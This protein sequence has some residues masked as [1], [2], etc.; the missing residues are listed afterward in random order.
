MTVKSTKQKT[1]V[2][3]SKSKVD[4]KSQIED[5]EKSQA[6][7]MIA[8]IQKES[9]AFT[10]SWNGFTTEMKSTLTVVKKYHETLEDYKEQMNKRRETLLSKLKEIVPTI[11]IRL[12]QAATKNKLAYVI[13]VNL[14]GLEGMSISSVRRLLDRYEEKFGPLFPKALEDK[15]GEDTDTEAGTQNH[16]DITYDIFGGKPDD[17]VNL[18]EGVLK[19]IEDKTFDRLVIKLNASRSKIKGFRLVVQ[20]KD[21]SET[22]TK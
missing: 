6:K 10:H 11:K 3:E 5:A 22:T 18:F 19:A 21:E 13:A 14:E 2:K 7:T 1:K 4:E 8:T 20:K 16:I 15:S 12:G 9:S 17:L